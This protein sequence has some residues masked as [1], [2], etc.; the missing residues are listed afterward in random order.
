[1]GQ[2][3]YGLLM[4]STVDNVIRPWI[5]VEMAS[6]HPLAGLVGVLGGLQEALGP[7]GIFLGPIVVAF[8][9]TVLTLLHREFASEPG[10]NVPADKAMSNSLPEDGGAAGA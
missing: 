10:P 8:L 1:V 9:Q 3:V 5:I 7:A 4:I 6:L 2:A